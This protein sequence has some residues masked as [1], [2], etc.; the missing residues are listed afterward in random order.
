VAHG[1]GRFVSGGVRLL[2]RLEGLAALAA[3]LALYAHAGFSW[4]I[5]ALFLLAPDLS[6]LGYLA[7]PRAGAAAHNLVHTYVLRWY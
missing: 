3:S 2:L 7:G 4:P 5:F 6:M 1:E